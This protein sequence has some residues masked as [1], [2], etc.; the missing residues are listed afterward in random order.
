MV[1]PLDV[2]ASYH[3]DMTAP[4]LERSAAEGLAADWYPQVEAAGRTLSATS[5]V[6]PEVRS[7]IDVIAEQ[8]AGPISQFAGTDP[9]L[10]QAVLAATLACDKGLRA[11]TDEIIAS[12][13]RLGLERLRQALRDL[14]DEA[15]TK[16]GRPAKHVAR[17][18]AEHVTVS[19]AQLATLLGV[20]PRTLQRWLS[21]TD[22]ASPEADDE[23][24]LRAVAQV[25]SHLRHV[26]TGPGVVRWFER[27][28]PH[29]A[30]KAPMTLLSDA[31]DI[32]TLLRLASLSRSTLAS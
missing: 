26:F 31:T 1:Q 25:V 24:R 11:E 15:P 32:P 7:L 9:Y 13:V 29:L 20:S 27:P 18:L 6:P 4:M 17:W 12:R 2:V 5:V 14:I 21:E 10:G 30:G 28:H 16:D 3:G 22:P 19:Q 23:V 8:L